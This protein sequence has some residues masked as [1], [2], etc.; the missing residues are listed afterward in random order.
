MTRVVD[1]SISPPRIAFGFR[2]Y[3]LMAGSSAPESIMARRCRTA[4][5]QP[6]LRQ[7]RRQVTELVCAERVDSD[8]SRCRLAGARNVLWP[9]VIGP[10]GIRRRRPTEHRTVFLVRAPLA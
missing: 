7:H 4:R 1:Y 8:R 3:L 6:R 2:D 9:N 5:R 10:P